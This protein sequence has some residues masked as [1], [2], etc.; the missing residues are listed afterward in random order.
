MTKKMSEETTDII[1][2]AEKIL[3]KHDDFD[4]NNFLK[5]IESST[6]NTPQ[7]SVSEVV[8]SSLHAQKPPVSNRS[9][10][11]LLASDILSTPK[12]G[13]RTSE[14]REL[15]N[16]AEFSQK[17]VEHLKT[18]LLNAITQNKHLNNTQSLLT[19][20]N[21]KLRQEIAN[22]HQ[23]YAAQAAQLNRENRESG[24][25]RT[26]YNNEMKDIELEIQDLS[27]TNTQLRNQND[28][29]SKEFNSIK[30]NFEKEKIKNQKFLKENENLKNVVLKKAEDYERIVKQLQTETEL[31]ATK[32]AKFLN[33][34]K[35][36]KSQYENNK[37]DS[38]SMADLC[39]KLTEGSA[40]DRRE[41]ERL[42]GELV[43]AK[44]ANERMSSLNHQQGATAVQSAEATGSSPE[45]FK[46]YMPALTKNQ[47]DL[48]IDVMAAQK[49]ALLRIKQVNT[50][51]KDLKST[52]NRQKFKK[53]S[54]PRPL[55]RTLVQPVFQP[56]DNLK[57]WEK[58]EDEKVN[59]QRVLSDLAEKE[60]ELDNIRVE[61][62]MDK[63]EYYDLKKRFCVLETQNA[64]QQ[65]HGQGDVQHVNIDH[66]PG[67]DF[68]QELNRKIIFLEKE[69]QKAKNAE[70]LAKKS[71]L[72]NKT[73]AHFNK[74]HSNKFKIFR[75]GL[76]KYKK[77][78]E[79]KNLEILKLKNIID[80]GA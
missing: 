20:E 52:L 7:L 41:I 35:N 2:K 5:N 50:E 71:N 19:R 13:F 77:S 48:I 65:G 18:E 14:E 25:E 46:I 60:Q 3:Q 33:E 49:R 21:T 42:R 1:K 36:L 78:I 69:L 56:E 57:V 38:S 68:I 79:T 66:I 72:L 27:K 32:E 15:I 47:K 17:R 67:T 59:T 63:L 37:N 10:L 54:R 31:F 40:S 23:S 44:N 29:I 53:R 4:I 11:P 75:S 16:D 58:L 26:T 76:K 51:N 80:A 12:N 74:L 24:Q 39:R 43:Q 8:T 73:Q 30:K 64:N 70:A 45:D 28:Q 61:R 22:L 34:L 55:A 62:A 6:S 9:N